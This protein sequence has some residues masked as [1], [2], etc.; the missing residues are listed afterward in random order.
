M[1]LPVVTAGLVQPAPPTVKVDSGE[2]RGAVADGVVSFRGIPFAAPPV[3]DLRWR[4]PQPAAKWTGVREASEFGAVVCRGDSEGRL[5]VRALVRLQL[6]VLR[7]TR[8]PLRRQL[9][10]RLQ[11]KA[12]RRRPRLPLHRP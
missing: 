5:R 10:A 11:P 6:R 7:P 12:A 2:L 3:G 4:P 9:Q 8:P 1:A